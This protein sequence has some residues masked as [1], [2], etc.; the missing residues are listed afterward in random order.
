MASF[1]V[2]SMY[3]LVV[4][5]TSS[6]IHNTV[7]YIESIE[8]MGYTVNDVP[9]IPKLLKAC[10]IL[11]M[12]DK[13]DFEIKSLRDE[14][15]KLHDSIDELKGLNNS[16]RSE[17]DD[18]RHL[19]ENLEQFAKDQNEDFHK[20]LENINSNYD[21]INK[22]LHE[23]ERVLMMKVAQ[24]IEFLDDKEGMTKMEYKRFVDRIP[25]RLQSKYQILMNEPEYKHIID[26]FD[27]DGDSQNGT[28]SP[29]TIQKLINDLC[30]EE[31]IDLL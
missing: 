20:V 12:Y 17:I 16:L 6:I 8:F 25:L 1:L 30:K 9:L 22:L 2:T 26:A 31:N 4:D 7:S 3:T 28:V 21:R 18:F 19:K 13:M 14:N 5:V 24:D 15:T 10:N 23:N 11:T 27:D 29:K